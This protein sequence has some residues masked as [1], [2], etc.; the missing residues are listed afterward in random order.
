MVDVG[1]TQG[2]PFL[3]RVVCDQ[4]ALVCPVSVMI[5]ANDVGHMFAFFVAW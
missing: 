5:A 3:V 4:D 2:A 1:R